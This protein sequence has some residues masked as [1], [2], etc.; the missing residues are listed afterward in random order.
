VLK[1]LVDENL[2]RSLAARLRQA[3]FDAL[4]VRDAGLAAASDATIAASAKREDRIII[5]ANYR[6][7]GNLLLFPLEQMPGIIVVKMP[8][9][10][11]QAVL[12]RLVA[13]VFA[14]GED[15]LLKRLNIVEPH[16]VR[17]RRAEGT[18]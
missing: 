12:S 6:H 10:N 14:A 11:M 18:N 1:F 16:R 15:R 8:R 7:F 9:S 17:R 3:G 2:P 4:D 13:F 5:T